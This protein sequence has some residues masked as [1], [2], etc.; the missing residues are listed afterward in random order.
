MK[1]TG[2]IRKVDELGRIVLPKELR[3]LHGLFC[4][5]PV[6]I[7][8]DGADIILCKYEPGCTF[9]G[10]ASKDMREIGGKFI[11]PTCAKKYLPLFSE[12][13]QAEKSGQ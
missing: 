11:C 5:T 3:D 7:L 2:I 6:E 10:T 12:A 8:V 4:G 9:C 13:A 1:A